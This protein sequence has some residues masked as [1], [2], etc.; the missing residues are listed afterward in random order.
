MEMKKR[1]KN[2]WGGESGYLKFTIPRLEVEL[3][4]QE[5]V[6]SNNDWKG[7]QV[8]DKFEYPGIFNR[9]PR[10]TDGGQVASEQLALN[11]TP[12]SSLK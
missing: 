8:K 9:W 7:K 3:R 4:N 10:Y 6:S 5:I 2:C 1:L 12:I 11:A